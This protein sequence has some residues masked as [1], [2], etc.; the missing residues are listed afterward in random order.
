MYSVNVSTSVMQLIMT[1]KGTH[2]QG[3]LSVNV[4]SGHT[5]YFT[6]HT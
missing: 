2:S 6:T 5:V 3:S 4:L 1:T